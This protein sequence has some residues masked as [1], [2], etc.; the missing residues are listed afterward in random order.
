MEP[1]KPTEPTSQGAR[2]GVYP[3]CGQCTDETLAVSAPD[4]GTVNGFG[5]VFYGAA[6][7]CEQCGSVVQRIFFCVLWVPLWPMGRYRIITTERSLTGLRRRYVGRML[8]RRP[9]R[10]QAQAEAKAEAGAVAEEAF[11]PQ[12]AAPPSR[13]ADHPDLRGERYQEAQDYWEFDFP[14]RA[15][16]VYEEVLAAHE[17]VLPADD[18]ATLELRQRVAEAYLAVGQLP[19]AMALLSQTHFHL[20]RVLGP[21][22]PDTCRAAHD[23]ANAYSQLVSAQDRILPLTVHLAHLERTVGL[24]DP[25]ALRVA[26]AL[27]SALLSNSSFVRALEMFEDAHARSRRTLGAD[28]PDTAYTLRELLA[29]CHLAEYGRKPD[30]FLAATRAR[31]RLYGPDARETLTAMRQLAGLYAAS[32]RGRSKAVDV[33]LI[34]LERCERTLGADD[35]LTA[36]VRRQL[37]ELT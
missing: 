22:H 20:T 16:P 2:Q 1:I 24:D 28:H 10:A 21:D 23:V 3:F 36:D 19:D 34:V 26:V 35:Q 25:R 29:A 30:D 15:L 5:T 9:G 8:P 31:E 4:S 11:R 18:P 32:R 7:S 17:A 13:L 6:E 37:A 12:P 27:G 14:E 33:L